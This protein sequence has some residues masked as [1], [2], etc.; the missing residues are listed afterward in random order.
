MLTVMPTLA[1]EACT[2]SAMATSPGRSERAA[3]LVVKPFGW[4]QSASWALAEARP[5]AVSA[6]WL[7]VLGYR[8]NGV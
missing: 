2:A 7:P 1:S 4:P 6:P 3:M 8:L 5:L